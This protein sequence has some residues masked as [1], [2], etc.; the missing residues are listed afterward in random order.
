MTRTL[1][2]RIRQAREH[3]GMSQTELARRIG[4]SATALK[5]IESGKTADPGVSRIIRIAETLNVTPDQLLGFDT[6]TQPL[7]RT[8]R[9]RVQQEDATDGSKQEELTFSNA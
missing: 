3:Y 8:Q 1:G 9:K 7:R 5:M 6:P 2:S 4:V